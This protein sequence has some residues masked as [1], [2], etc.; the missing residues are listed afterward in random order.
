MPKALCSHRPGGLPVG[1]ESSIKHDEN[2]GDG[3]DALREPIVGKG[4]LQDSVCPEHHAQN[5]EEE[6]GGD[7]DAG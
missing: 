1:A 7:A 5:D 2:Q 4:N 3:T 6:K